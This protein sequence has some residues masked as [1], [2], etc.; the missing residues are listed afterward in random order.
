MAILDQECKELTG[1]NV[2]GRCC[3]KPGWP[4]QSRGIW[5]NKQRFKD[6]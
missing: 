5:G 1:N 3:V 6:V 4:G 2:E